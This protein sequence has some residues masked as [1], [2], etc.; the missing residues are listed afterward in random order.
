MRHVFLHTLVGA[1]CKQ[2]RKIAVI[3]KKGKE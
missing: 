1:M 3:G 2:G